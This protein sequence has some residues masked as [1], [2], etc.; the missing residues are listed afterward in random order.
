MNTAEELLCDF[1]LPDTVCDFPLDD[2]EVVT[3]LK[4]AEMLTHQAL[5]AAQRSGLSPSALSHMEILSDVTAECIDVVAAPPREVDLNL[6]EKAIETIIISGGAMADEAKTSAGADLA[7]P[8]EGAA[9]SLEIESPA[10]APDAGS[11]PTQH[12][13]ALVTSLCFFAMVVVPGLILL[14]CA[15]FGFIIARCESWAFAIGFMYF[16]GNVT[17]LGEPLTNNSPKS[18]VGTVVDIVVSCWC[19]IF[20]GAAIGVTAQCKVMERLQDALPLEGWR[21]ALVLL[22]LVPGFVMLAAV[23]IAALLAVCEDWSI[24]VGFRYMISAMCGLGNPL[25]QRTPQSAAGR[26]IAIVCASWQM[27]IGGTVVGLTGAVPWLERA[28]RAMEAEFT[29]R[30]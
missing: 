20:A 7:G 27:A 22:V 14:I 3:L 24:A 30:L 28:L 8:A 12:T 23:V 19:L 5:A 25:T 1:P 17:G 15:A 11:G 13:R 6:G 21:G 29:K 16:A 26:I 10:A 18:A 2:T 9:T 4:R